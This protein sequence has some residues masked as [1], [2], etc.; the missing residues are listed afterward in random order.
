MKKLFRFIWYGWFA[1]Y[2]LNKRNKYNMTEH[3]TLMLFHYEKALYYYE[4]YN[5]RKYKE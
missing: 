1:D 3:P 4:K 2:H 5:G